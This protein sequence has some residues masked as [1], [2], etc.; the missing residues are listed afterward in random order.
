MKIELT[1][2]QAEYIGHRLTLILNVR[3]SKDHL[4]RFETGF[5]TKTEEGLGRVVARVIEEVT[6]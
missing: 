5:G 6:A 2:E 4:D 3:R 1:K